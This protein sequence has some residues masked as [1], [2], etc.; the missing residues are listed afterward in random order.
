MEVWNSPSIS[1]FLRPDWLYALVRE[2]Q[3]IAAV[4]GSTWGPE[5][6]AAV[7]NFI[8][9]TPRPESPL[10]RFFLRAVIGEVRWRAALSPAPASGRQIHVSDPRFGRA[11]KIIETRRK[12]IALSQRGIAA[13]VGLSGGH[14]G[15]L[16]RAHIGCGV[17]TY[18]THLRIREATTLLVG[19]CKSVKEVSAAVGF[20]SEAQC[21]RCF[22]RMLGVT[23][24]Y[25]RRNDGAHR[26]EHR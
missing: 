5:R 4:L 17:R 22:K 7:E 25:F 12:D 6:A 14:L 8:R 1:T 16:F 15:R 24:L 3:L 20:A 2:C 11:L 19:T 9:R 26:L 18:V 21:D 13:D 10:E 23:P